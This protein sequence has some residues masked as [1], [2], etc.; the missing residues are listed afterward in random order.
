[1]LNS[2]QSSDV[3]KSECSQSIELLTSLLGLPYRLDAVAIDWMPYRLDVV[4]IVKH[5]DTTVE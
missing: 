4:D 1:M 3:L 2:L 5:V